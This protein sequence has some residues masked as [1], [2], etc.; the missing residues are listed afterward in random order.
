MKKQLLKHWR[1]VLIIIAT[2]F[3]AILFIVA[4]NNNDEVQCEIITTPVVE[5]ESTTE[6]ETETT[7]SAEIETSEQIIVSTS[8]IVCEWLGYELSQYE[9]ELLCRTTFCEAGNQDLETQ[10]MVALTI[11]NRLCADEFPNS[12]HDI[13]YQERA[14]A[15]TKWKDFEKYEWTEQV[16]QAVNI[17]LEVNEHPYDMYYFRTKH[18]HKFGQPYMQ[19]DDLWFSIEE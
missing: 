16:E 3:L 10:V 5:I 17:A 14:Y 7:I 13:V 4:N 18:Y 12:I 9:Y 15:V 6:L 11:L 8:Q 1:V 19:S 2:V